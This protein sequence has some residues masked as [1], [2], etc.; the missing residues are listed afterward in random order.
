M[1]TLRNAGFTLL[2]LSIVLVIIGLIVGGILVG[3]DLIR[4][5]EVRST[6]SQVEK[7]NAAVNTF[8]TKF[9]GIPGDINQASA[10]YF[11]IFTLTVAT[12][13]GQGDGN[14]LLEGGAAAS[15]NP[16]GET[17]V[18]WRHLSDANL[19]DGSLGTNGNSI[20]VAATGLVTGTVTTPSQSMPI[21]KLS[22]QNLFIVYSASGLNYYQLIPVSTITN[23][24]A[25]TFNATGITP[26]QAF[27]MDTKLDDGQPNTG[28]VIARDTGA[29]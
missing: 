1:K 15:T 9:D 6:I 14:G 12:T 18:F 24:P 25:Y 7:Y 22:Q 5:A 3:Q 8:R 23:A 27:N 4:A 20:P 21:S 17:L 10:S 13:V 11:Q 29:T 26:I 28:I 16:Q 2:E 19:V